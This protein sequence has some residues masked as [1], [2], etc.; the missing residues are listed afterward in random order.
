MPQNAKTRNYSK[1]CIALLFQ[2]QQPAGVGLNKPQVQYPESDYEEIAPPTP[3]TKAKM[4]H[5]EVCDLC[6]C[7]EAMVRCV[8]CS[9]QVFCL[10]C[11]DMYHR[12]PKRTS[13]ARK[14]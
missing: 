3:K 11:D 6:G 12:H 1:V 2:V 4:A 8:P 14:V 9:G 10:A 7:Q 5:I 13:H